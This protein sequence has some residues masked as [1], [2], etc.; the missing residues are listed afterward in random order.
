VQTDTS[1]PKPIRP[2]VQLLAFQ[3]RSWIL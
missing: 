2:V 1:H 3:S